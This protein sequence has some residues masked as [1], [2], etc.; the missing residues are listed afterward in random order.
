M[1]KQALAWLV[2]IMVPAMLAA[3]SPSGPSKGNA[4]TATAES[5]FSKAGLERFYAFLDDEIAKGRVPGAV[6]LVSRRGT[7]VHH[8]AYGLADRDAKRPMRTDDVFRIYSM[9]KPVVSVA[10]L[11]LYEEGKFQLDDPLERYIPGFKDVKVFTG[12]DARGKMI[13]EQPHRKPTIHDAFRH[14]LGISAGGGRTPVDNLY[15]EKGLIVNRLDSLSQQMKLL[16]EVPLLFHPGERWLYGFGH[17]VQAY[18][19][20]Y[21]SGIPLDRFLQERIFGPLR[22]ADTGYAVGLNQPGRVVRLH[23]VAETPPS[24]PAIDMRPSTYERFATHPLGT[25]GL[26]STAA[27]YARFSQMLLNGGEL[28][29]VRIL[30]RKTVELM[31]SNHLPP[32]IGTL[33]QNDNAPGV[34]YGLGVSVMLDP[35]AAGKLS[36]PGTFGWT[37]A[38]TTSFFIDPKED[39]VAILM[40]QKWPYDARLLD[41]F[42]TMV[43]QAIAD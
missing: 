41:E 1:R 6:V 36:S 3:C 8:K 26:W 21:L 27:D 4:S 40:T 42:Q 31:A 33:A 5:G 37:G 13:L 20:E 11:T 29:G 32:A 19:V 16:G 43:Y 2:T 9:T 28:D 15:R 34:G 30:G 18:L 17:D 12:S 23:D 14:T 24:N 38:A 39:L 22:M 10:L 7:T 25:L 35:A